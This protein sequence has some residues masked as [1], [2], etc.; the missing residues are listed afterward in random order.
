MKLS[1]DVSEGDGARPR[2]IERVRHMQREPMK[3]RRIIPT[4]FDQLFAQ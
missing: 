3:D 2:Q 4:I 1:N